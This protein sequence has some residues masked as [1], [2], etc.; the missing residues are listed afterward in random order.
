MFLFTRHEEKEGSRAKATSAPLLTMCDEE[1]PHCVT[2]QSA[3]TDSS[4]RRRVRR[5][6]SNSLAGYL[7]GLL[8]S[9]HGAGHAASVGSLGTT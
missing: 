7:R 8:A 5:I 4:A 1:I 3:P 2:N 9:K 6:A